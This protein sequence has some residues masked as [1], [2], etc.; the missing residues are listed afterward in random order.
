MRLAIALALAGL[1]AAAGAVVANGH[2]NHE[3]AHSLKSR[4][5]IP[6]DQIVTRRTVGANAVEFD[7]SGGVTYR[8]ELASACDAVERLGSGASFGVTNAET[9][10]LCAG[11][12]IKIFDPAEVQATGL[13]NYPYCR[14]GKFTAVD[15]TPPH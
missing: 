10:T 14:L 5:C 3:P 11:D 8:N 13:R 9:G 2:P 4:T 12:R 15:A 1:S 7:I 6:L